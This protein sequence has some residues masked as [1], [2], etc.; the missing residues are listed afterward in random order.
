M[1]AMI[2]GLGLKKCQVMMGLMVDGLVEVVSVSEWRCRLR[3]A[4][5]KTF[6]NVVRYGMVP[7]TQ[8]SN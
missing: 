5:G 2:G 7:K 8:L 6:D 1:K 3:V 4:R